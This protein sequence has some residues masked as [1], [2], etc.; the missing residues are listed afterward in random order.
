MHWINLKGVI[1][2]SSVSK[3][4]KLCVIGSHAYLHRYPV[5]GCLNDHHTV[6]G[7]LADVQ[8]AVLHVHHLPPAAVLSVITQPQG[9]VQVVGDELEVAKVAMHAAVFE[10]VIWVVGCITLVMEYHKL[11]GVDACEPHCWKHKKNKNI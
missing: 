6:H 10:A 1:F 2:S 9:P 7:W 3:T 8:E 11:A 4:C 5:L